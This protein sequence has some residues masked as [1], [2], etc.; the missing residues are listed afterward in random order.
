M[1]LPPTPDGY[2]NWNEYITENAPSLMVSQ[3]LTFQEAKASLKLL[4]VA[5]PVRQDIGTPSYRE[6]NVFTTWADRTVAPT[7]GRPWVTGEPPVSGDNI[8]TMS[9]DWLVTK[10]GAGLITK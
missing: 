1:S 9:G 6:Y 4:D 10:S 2:S 8:V 5:M 3:G 7:V